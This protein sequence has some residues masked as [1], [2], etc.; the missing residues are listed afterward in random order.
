MHPIVAFL[1]DLLAL[2]AVIGIITGLAFVVFGIT[3]VQPA[4][5]SL[6]ARVLILPGALALWPYIL[7]RW[8]KAGPA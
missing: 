7:V 1:L 3:R 8:I 5:V 6:G 4:P 2:Y